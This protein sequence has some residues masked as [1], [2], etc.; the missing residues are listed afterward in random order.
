MSDEHKASLDQTLGQDAANTYADQIYTKSVR[1]FRDPVTTVKIQEKD[2]SRR[3]T[4]FDFLDFSSSNEP[5]AVTL[6][7]DKTVSIFSLPQAPAPLGLSSQAVMARGGLADAGLEFFA[8]S[9]KSEVKISSTI[10]GIQ[11]SSIPEACLRVTTKTPT[12]GNTKQAKGSTTGDTEVNT[13]VSSREKRERLLS[14]GTYG[15]PLSLPDALSWMSVPRL[16]CKEGY[17]LDSAKNRDLLCDDQGL[18]ELWDWIGR[19]LAN[20]WT[21]GSVRLT[22]LG[23]RANSS[24]ESMI[25]H[26]ADMNYLGV[27]SIWTN[28]IG[29]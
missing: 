2:S 22:F 10:K 7:A 14:A 28:R 3:V 15:V 9:S 5:S 12:K 13:H 25:I 1:D 24:N 23:A 19:T 8:P 26:G 27:Y 20:I 6:L 29:G 4:S 11:N 21:G 17:L 18:Q 16:R